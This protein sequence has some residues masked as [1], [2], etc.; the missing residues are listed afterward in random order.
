M[1]LKIIRST[2]FKVLRD[3]GFWSVYDTF[4]QE[5]TNYVYH[6]KCDAKGH[7]KELNKFEERVGFE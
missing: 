4:Q 6:K 5:S 2:R 1:R 7:A 3:T